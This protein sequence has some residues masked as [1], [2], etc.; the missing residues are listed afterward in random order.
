MRSRIRR[1]ADDHPTLALL[2]IAGVALGG[3]VCMCLVIFLL[4]YLR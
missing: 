1:L 4:A 2:S 3:I